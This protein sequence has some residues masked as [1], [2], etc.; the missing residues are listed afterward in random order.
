MPVQENFN[1]PGLLEAGA[2]YLRVAVA[3]QW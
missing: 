2:E 3:G 1:D